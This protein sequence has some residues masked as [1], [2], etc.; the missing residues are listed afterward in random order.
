MP[1]TVP[2]L[3]I[4]ATGCEVDVSNVFKRAL[5]RAQ[6]MAATGCPRMSGEEH[7]RLRHFPRR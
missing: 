2:W 5:T 1:P 6:F 3:C 4:A 7:A